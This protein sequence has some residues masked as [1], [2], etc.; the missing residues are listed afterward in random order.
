MI[1]DATVEVTCDRP[2]CRESVR[3]PLGFVYGGV[4]HTRGRYDHDDAKVARRLAED[5]GWVVRGENQYCSPECE[6]TEPTTP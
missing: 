1:H 4:M 3:V 6:P 5:F 2:R